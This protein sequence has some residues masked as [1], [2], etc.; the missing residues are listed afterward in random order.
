MGG[1]HA[2]SSVT[3]EITTNKQI[4][5]IT[6]KV[7][8]FTSKAGGGITAVDIIIDYIVE[9]NMLKVVARIGHELIGL[10]ICR[11]CQAF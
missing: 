4:Q 10:A 6:N 7:Q 9:N 3:T 1:G 11:R 2:L 8:I 5:T